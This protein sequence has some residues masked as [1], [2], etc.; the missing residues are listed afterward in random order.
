VPVTINVT[1]IE[2]VAVNRAPNV[3]LPVR[4]PFT[5]RGTVTDRAHAP[6]P[7][8]SVTLVGE[9][10]DIW[11]RT[12]TDST[13]SYSLSADPGQ[14]TGAYG[15]TATLAG[16]VDGHVDLASIPNG[17]TL[18][19]AFVLLAFGTLTGL[20]TDASATPATPIVGAQITAGPASAA[21]DATGRYTLQLAPGSVSVSVAALGYEF[22]AASVTVA[23]GG[24]AEQDFTLEEASATLTGAVLDGNTGLAVHHAF[25]RVDGARGVRAS[26]DGAYTLSRVPAGP[27]R[28][29]ATAQGYR[30][31]T[32]PVQIVAHDTVSMNIYLTASSPNPHPP[33]IAE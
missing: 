13:G 26:P 21:S 10:G 17:A 32:V 9:P 30:A 8:V 12:T 31:E 29:V 23:P 27:A 2:G 22:A 1:V 4:H 3:A 18:T 6:L 15:L 20:I 33:A 25:V 24:T 14:Y 5:V 19:E 7:G 16:Y 28:V 11:L